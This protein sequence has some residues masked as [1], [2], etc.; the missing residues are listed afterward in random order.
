ML[1]SLKRP[2]SVKRADHTGVVVI[3][4]TETAAIKKARRWLGNGPLTARPF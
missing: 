4:R 1:T 2:W 3:A